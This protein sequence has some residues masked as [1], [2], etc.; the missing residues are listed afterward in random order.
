[1]MSNSREGREQTC[2]SSLWHRW[3]STIRIEIFRFPRNTQRKSRMS[4]L[5][6]I[7]WI[8]HHL[9]TR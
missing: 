2:I 8:S 9:Q 7:R 5:I 6:S 1:M 3:V 4:Y